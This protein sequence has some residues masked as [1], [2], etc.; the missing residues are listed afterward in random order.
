M[1]AIITLLMQQNSWA[2]QWDTSKYWSLN[3]NV[4]AYRYLYDTA[5]RVSMIDT[6]SW[7]HRGGY[8]RTGHFQSNYQITVPWTDKTQLTLLALIYFLI[9]TKT[10][11][12]ARLSS[13]NWFMKK[14]DKLEIVFLYLYRM[15]MMNSPQIWTQIWIY[16]ILCSCVNY[17]FPNK[18]K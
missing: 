16:F 2:C 4:I 10:I 3:P 12:F 1:H 6:D 18:I 15:T 9:I 14:C 11:S 7:L 17:L 8:E 5:V 13:P